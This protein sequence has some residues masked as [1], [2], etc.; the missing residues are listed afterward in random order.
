MSLIGFIFVIDGGW[1]WLK[2]N[3]GTRFGWTSIGKF[4][5]KDKKMVDDDLHTSC[6]LSLEDDSIPF[7]FQQ[8]L[9]FSHPLIR[10]FIFFQPKSFLHRYRGMVVEHIPP[11][12]LSNRCFESHRALLSIQC[13]FH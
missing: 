11:F 4:Q 13:Q 3:N 8:F 7:Q 6:V 9:F 2:N 12:L 5:F 10:E 1:V